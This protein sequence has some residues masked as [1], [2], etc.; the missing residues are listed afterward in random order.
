MWNEPNLVVFWTGSQADY[1]RLYAEAARAVKAVDSRLPVGGPSTAASEWIEPLAAYAEQHELPLDFVTSHTYGNLPVDAQPALR[2]HGFDKSPIWWTEWGVG[3]THFGPIH[4][5]VI[6]APFVLSGYASVQNRMD[7]LAYWVI[8]DHFEELGRPPSLFH[9]GFGLLTVGNLRKPRFWAVEAGR[10]ARRRAARRRA[11][12]R[13]RRHSGAGAWPAGTEDGTVDLLL[14]NGTINAELHGR[15]P[16]LDRTIEISL[17][18]LAD[19]GYTRAAVAR[20]DAP[21][22]QHPAAAT[23]TALDWPDAAADGRAARHATSCDVEAAAATSTGPAA[24]F[25]IELPMPGIARLRLTPEGRV[26]RPDGR[27]SGCRGRWPR[28]AG[29]DAA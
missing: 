4:D 1:F 16:A 11:D 22:L 20:V 19:A 5:G 9:N 12:R 17:T 10:G 15:R 18:G 29:R 14:W 6:G 8:S 21:A 13:R 25:E 28:R 3:S 7:A 23:R 26:M 24:T 27:G 2:R